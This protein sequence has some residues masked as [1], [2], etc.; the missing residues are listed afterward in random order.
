MRNGDLKMSKLA[1]DPIIGTT[2]W[3]PDATH[4]T[5]G[6]T[7]KHLVITTVRGRF[8]DVKGTMTLNTEK[9][10]A[11]SVEVEIAVS[12]IDTG[13]E[14]RDAHLVT[15]DFLD[16]AAHPLITFKSR[17]VEGRP[18]LEG[19]RFKIVGDLT[20]RGVTR[21][22]TLDATYHGVASDPWGGRR[23]GFQAST[24]IDRRDYGLN[25]NQA[26]ETGGL[27]VSNE[28]KIE[29]ELQATAAPAAKAA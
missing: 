28:V 2:T 12:S 26:L 18:F 16:V 22:V 8:Q 11:S 7:A 14:Q 10:E 4:T 3:T 24:A 19:G 23:A 20:I 13:V 6:F 29:I 1:L 9:P 5:V 25:F 21:E 17:R 15:S 27:L